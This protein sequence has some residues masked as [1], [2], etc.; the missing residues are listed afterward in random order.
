[1]NL[2]L[3]RLLGTVPALLEILARIKQQRSS[4]TPCE[5][6]LA[7]EDQVRG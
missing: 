1:M 5:R 4:V 3:I 6:S 2:N 7:S